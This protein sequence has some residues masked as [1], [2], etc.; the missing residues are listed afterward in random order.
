MVSWS[1]PT[2]SLLRIPWISRGW[3][4]ATV[5]AQ[6]K[7]KKNLS[8]KFILFPSGKITTLKQASPQPTRKVVL[9][10]KDSAARRGEIQIINRKALKYI[11]DLQTENNYFFFCLWFPVLFISEHEFRPARLD[12]E[13]R[14]WRMRIKWWKMTRTGKEK[15]HQT[16]RKPQRQRLSSLLSSGSSEESVC[17]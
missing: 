5:L 3:S 15:S 12:G 10:N 8:S 14:Q 1:S 7:K 9:V 17:T 16:K 13:T 2:P 4:P 11:R 6:V